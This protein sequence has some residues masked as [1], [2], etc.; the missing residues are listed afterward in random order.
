[1]SESE[2]RAEHNG[3][4]VLFKRQTVVSNA[5]LPHPNMAPL[6]WTIQVYQ[7]GN[8]GKEMISQHKNVFFLPSKVR[9]TGKHPNNVS[10]CPL[11]SFHLSL[12]HHSQKWNSTQTGNHTHTSLNSGRCCRI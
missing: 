10:Q 3:I 5:V 6:G 11:L 12:S 9:T 8:K 4:D 1:M 7:G 2:L